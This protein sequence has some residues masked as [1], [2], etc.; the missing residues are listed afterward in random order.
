MA[1]I[2]SEITRRDLKVLRRHFTMRT[3][4]GLTIGLMGMLGLVL[5][6][7][8]G[9][10]YRRLALDN[11]RTLL[12]QL[13]RLTVNDRLHEVDARARELGLA[14][15][16]SHAFELAFGRRD[17]AAM[18]HQLD[19]LRIRQ[20]A[21]DNTRALPRL[22]VLDAG[23][24]T[25]SV[26]SGNRSATP[27]TPA[28]CPELMKYARAH[29]GTDHL[30]IVS[31]MCLVDGQ[32]RD[33]AMIP[34][35]GPQVE[36][37]IEVV[38]SIA[39][40][41]MLVGRKIGLPIKLSTGN[42]DV[43]YQSSDW[44]LPQAMGNALV[45]SYTLTAPDSTPMLRISAMNNVEH[46]NADM[47]DALYIVMAVAGGT[48]LLGVLLAFI[49]LDKTALTPL[50]QLALQLRRVQKDRSHLG[51][52]VS[53][54]GI[55]EVKELAHDFNRMTS[56]LK[57]LYGTLEH[58]A[59]TDPLTRLPNRVRFHDILR[60][61]THLSARTNCSFALLLMDLD[62]FKN[63]NDTLGHHVGDQLLREVSARLR[64]GL[65][66][67]DMITRLDD[68]TIARLDGKM[69]ARLGGDEFAALLPCV[70]SAEDATVVA[71]K[72]LT[73][74][75]EPFFID[76]HR[77]DVGISIGIAMYPD[78]GG[79]ND[80]LLRRADAAMYHAKNNQCGFALHERIQDQASLV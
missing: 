48:T 62:R 37:Y 1:E 69:V 21:F 45:A 20:L 41:L 43:L 11:Q 67:S 8:T 24:K 14:I 23:F 47:H 73:T 46:L 50:R 15:R 18:T 31:G 56:E 27:H 51:E 28:E 61:F 72:L 66:E 71:R 80:T 68:H 36:G 39:A 64:G 42:G 58:M 78:H 76:G 34:I 65:R 79:D 4:L 70:G 74:M 52:Q 2:D 10:F 16:D 30:Q 44:P 29:R 19:R 6:L 77:L 57:R 60:E 25:V 35:S 32:P 59:F 55:A 9:E 53:A 22:I 38:S 13:M 26:S 5:A 17:R 33:A 40:D 49:V 63:V 3:T 7:T 12:V 54:G 75:Q